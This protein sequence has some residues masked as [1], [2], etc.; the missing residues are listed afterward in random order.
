M[1]F[2]NLTPS[3]QAQLTLEFDP[4]EFTTRIIDLLTPVGKGNAD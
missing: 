4:Q 3:I 1:L 2:D